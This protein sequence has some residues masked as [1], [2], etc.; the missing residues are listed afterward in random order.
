MQGIE[1]E[2]IERQLSRL[3]ASSYFSHG[4][5]CP[6]F[7]RFVVLHSLDG[8]VDLLKERTIGVN[9]FGRDP[10]YD[11][12]DDP[13]VRVTAGEV[14]KRLAQYYNQAEHR[15]ELRIELEPGSYIA[16]F[17]PPDPPPEPAGE[18]LAPTPTSV[19]EIEAPSPRIL[20]Q[21][22]RLKRRDW[23][24][25]AAGA[26]LATASIF[27][28]PRYLSRKSALDRF[29][30]PL[31]ANADGPVLVCIG[32]RI[33]VAPSK[34]SGTGDP[35]RLPPSMTEP[36]LDDVSV[37]QT[38]YLG[39][40]NV[41]LID[42]I[43]MCRISSLLESRNKK[44]KIQGENAITLADLRLEAAVMIGAYSNDWTLRLTGPLRFHFRSDE[45]RYWVHDAQNPTDRSR[46]IP[47][48]TPNRDVHEDFAVITRVR[49]PNT[50]RVVVLFGG[51]NAYGTEACSELLTN[52]EYMESA[53]AKFPAD[54]DHRNV[55]VVLSTQVIKGQAGPPRFITAHVW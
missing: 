28:V 49:D 22:P 51:I 37:F 25:G 9:V 8:A 15:H 39:S 10:G 41:A 53:S 12:N 29:W 1:Q 17:K 26:S 4:K 7:L 48:A 34:P 42:A 45:T 55:Q 38:Y 30:G 23:L 27:T 46:S 3:L 31:L 43:A 21:A 18:P 16:G 11:T 20:K 40:Q 33:F 35:P 54:W 5:R 44:V 6:G 19:I 14:R 52:P 13:V 2:E 24:F 36:N 32:Q 50:D 47:Y